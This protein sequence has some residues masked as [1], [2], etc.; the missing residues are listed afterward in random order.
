MRS[1]ANVTKYMD[2]TVDGTNPAP[3]DMVNIPLFTTG[4]INPNGGCLGFLNHQQY[5]YL[6]WPSYSHIGLPSPNIWETPFPTNAMQ[7]PNSGHIDVTRI[8]PKPHNMIQCI[9]G[10]SFN[11]KK[12]HLQHLHTFALR[13]CWW[14]RNPARKPVEVGGLSHYLQRL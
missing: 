1:R 3:V 10:K 12:S 7:P 4:F 8:T 11:N 9:Q 13:Y 14:F 6:V 5:G 2:A